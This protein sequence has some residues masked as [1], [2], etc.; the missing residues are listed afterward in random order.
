MDKDKAFTLRMGSSLHKKVERLA[1]KADRSVG[2]IIR[3]AIEEYVAKKR[4]R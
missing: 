2:Y 3:R 1:A 4:A